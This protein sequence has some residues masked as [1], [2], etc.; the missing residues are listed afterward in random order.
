M[1]FKIL[2]TQKKAEVFRVSLPWQLLLIFDK[3]IYL[4]IQ[5]NANAF[6][7]FKDIE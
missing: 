2:N 1:L 4:S 5:T 3:R 6:E 7:V